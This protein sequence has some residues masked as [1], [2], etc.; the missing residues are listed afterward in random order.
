MLSLLYKYSFLFTDYGS[1]TSVLEAAVD[2]HSGCDATPIEGGAF[3]Q[4][5]HDLQRRM[6]H[7]QTV[8]P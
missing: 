6:E 7:V 4:T 1:D 3:C 8:H 5:T 2:L